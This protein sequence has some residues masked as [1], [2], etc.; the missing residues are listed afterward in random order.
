MGPK[1]CPQ[2][3]IISSYRACDIVIAWDHTGLVNG[4]LN[5]GSQ[6]WLTFKGLVFGISLSALLRQLTK[7]MTT[8]KNTSTDTQFLLLLW[9]SAPYLT[10]A[11]LSFSIRH[12][13]GMA[14]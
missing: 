4:H 6:A 10:A 5:L 14:L 9:N 8:Y 12:W 13:L 3:Y 11:S 1:Q 2:F 7:V